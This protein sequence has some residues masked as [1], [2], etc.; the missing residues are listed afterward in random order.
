MYFVRSRWKESD[1]WAKVTGWQIS[2][3][4]YLFIWLHRVLAAER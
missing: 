4:I 2:F 1:S 3:N